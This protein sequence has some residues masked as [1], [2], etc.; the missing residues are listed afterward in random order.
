MIQEFNTILDKHAQILPDQFNKDDIFKHS[1]IQVVKSVWI[2]RRGQGA[3]YVAG[4]DPEPR[5]VLS[6]PS[7]APKN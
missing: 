6:A 4:S 1:L 3:G 2:R 5:M 7:G